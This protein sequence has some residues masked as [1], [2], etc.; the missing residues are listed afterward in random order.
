MA[1]PD[2]TA[3]ESVQPT[4]GSQT[5]EQELVRRAQMGSSAA[6]ERLV[7]ERGPELYRYLAL[8]LRNESDARDALQE[9]LTAA[10]Q[11]LPTLREPSKFWAWLVSIA[12][13][14][15][16]DAVRSRAPLVLELEAVGDDGAEAA[17]IRE[18][19]DRLPS[20]FREVLLLRYGLQLSEQE[21]ANVL[22]V[23]V[24]TIKSRSARA[25]KAL[26]ELLA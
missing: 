1:S 7:V 18:A 8:R 26:E 5:H 21:A 14:K 22:G 24:G 10:W 17:E 4:G 20:R 11:S 13:H 6:F 12:A 15:A 3:D 16:A 9:T 2:I 25:R 19:F 23:R